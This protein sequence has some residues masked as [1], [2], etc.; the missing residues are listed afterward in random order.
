MATQFT[1][2][3]RTAGR[4]AAI[5]MLASFAL[6]VVGFYGM[7]VRLLV[8]GNAGATAANILASPTIFRLSVVLDVFYAVG[9][10][11]TAVALYRLLAPI[12]RGVAV[13]AALLR[14]AYALMWLAIA[15]HLLAALRLLSEPFPSGQPL[16]QRLARLELIAASDGYYIGLP[17]WGLASGLVTWLLLKSRYVPRFLAFAGMIAS[18]WATLSGSMF[19][20]TPQFGKAINLYSLDTPLAIYEILLAGWIL[21]AG[22]RLGTSVRT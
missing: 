21:I 19:L 5:A 8:P 14:S 9:L 1:P 12:G 7:Y 17:L 13:T 2:E 4:V 20:V 15:S 6:V 11:V 10:I 18:A 3:Q 16:T 22:L